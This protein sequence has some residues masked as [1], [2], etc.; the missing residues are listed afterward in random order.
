MSSRIAGGFFRRI[1]AV[2]PYYRAPQALERTLAAL[3]AA[4]CQEPDIFVRDNSVDNVLFTV[5]ANEGFAHWLSAGAH[6]FALLLNHDA[7]LS[8]DA[9]DCMLA[10]MDAHPRAGVCAPVSLDRQGA[11]KWCGGSDSLPWGRHFTTARA[12]LPAAP[13]DTRWANGACLLIRLQ[14]LREVGLFD[15]TMR[16]V[17]S[18]VDFSYRARLQGW[19]VLVCP[20]AF[21]Q[22]ELSGSSA[23]APLWLQIVKLQDQI[24]FAEKWGES[25]EYSALA[26]EAERMPPQ[27]IRE[28]C[29]VS[30]AQIR[31]LETALQR[32]RAI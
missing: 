17:F 27:R 24:R 20:Q 22:H 2:I 19:R 28:L 6:E 13:Y 30:R 25:A 11:V 10:V 32:E 14:T 1:G 7:E 31:Q 15:A 23:A 8:R 4:G 18:D 21:L 3:R 12:Q 16:F 26:R 5:A 29:A 9:L